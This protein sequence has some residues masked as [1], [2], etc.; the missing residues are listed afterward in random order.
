MVKNRREKIQ[1]RFLSVVEFRVVKSIWIPQWFFNYRGINETGTKYRV[2]KEI[3]LVK[4][5]IE[6]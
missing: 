5:V 1:K 2:K 3:S 4:T 6:Y